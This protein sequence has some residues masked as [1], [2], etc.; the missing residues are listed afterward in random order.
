M[1][2][3]SPKKETFPQNFTICLTNEKCAL[4]GYIL[5]LCEVGGLAFGQSS[6]RGLSQIWLHMK[7]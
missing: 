6:T 1:W 5:Y 7:G 3:H 4:R 2:G